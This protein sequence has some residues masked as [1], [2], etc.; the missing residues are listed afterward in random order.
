MNQIPYDNR[1]VKKVQKIP[2]TKPEFSKKQ[3]LAEFKIKYSVDSLINFDL[4]AE[5]TGKTE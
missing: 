2:Y 5:E 1:M 3:L 4:L